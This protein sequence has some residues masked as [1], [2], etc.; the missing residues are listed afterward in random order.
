M[1]LPTSEANVF[2]KFAPGVELSGAMIA[3][4][5]DR[6]CVGNVYTL[7]RRLYDRGLVVSRPVKGQARLYK[8][9]ARG[10]RVLKAWEIWKKAWQ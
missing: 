6:I 7:L 3:D 8:L 4:I 1:N 5:D 2:E 10:E 9:T